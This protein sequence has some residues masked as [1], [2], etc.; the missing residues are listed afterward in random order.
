MG[1]D[2]LPFGASPC[3][4]AAARRPEHEFL[5]G[6]NGC[7]NKHPPVPRPRPTEI[8]SPS[9]DDRMMIGAARAGAWLGASLLQGWAVTGQQGRPRTLDTWYP[10]T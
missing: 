6:V 7:A 3:M 9:V 4:Y 5:P 10:R 2:D 1:G 8:D